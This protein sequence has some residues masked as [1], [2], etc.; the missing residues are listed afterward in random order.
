M[1]CRLGGLFYRYYGPRTLIK[2]NVKNLKMNINE[3]R[4]GILVQS[5][6]LI[7]GLII[8]HEWPSEGL[9]LPL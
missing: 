2:V 5:L 4:E 3:E 6:F 8:I 9:L 7:Y 1:R